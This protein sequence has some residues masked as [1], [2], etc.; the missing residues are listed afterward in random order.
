MFQIFIEVA[1]FVIKANKLN[2]LF[3]VDVN[4]PQEQP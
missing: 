3:L 1:S 2:E 4:K